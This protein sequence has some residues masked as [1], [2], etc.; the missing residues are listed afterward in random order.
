M[1]EADDETIARAIA[2]VL[3]GQTPHGSTLRALVRR[4]LHD[5]VDLT[6]EGVRFLAWEH[7]KRREQ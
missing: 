7:L 4:G 5:G 2:L 6:D 3:T 1:S